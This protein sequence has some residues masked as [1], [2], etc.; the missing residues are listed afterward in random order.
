MEINKWRARKATIGRSIWIRI[1]H[2]LE[3]QVA[4]RLHQKIV[5]RARAIQNKSILPLKNCIGGDG[6]EGLAHLRITSD[7]KKS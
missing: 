5:C 7:P 4:C 6:K 2:F 3:N 1:K